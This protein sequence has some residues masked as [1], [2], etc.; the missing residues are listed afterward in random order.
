MGTDYPFFLEHDDVSEVA[1]VLRD[2]RRH[3]DEARRRARQAA[4]SFSMYESARRLEGSFTRAEGEP[5]GRSAIQ[6]LRML[7]TGHDFRFAGGLVEILESRSDIELHV[8]HWQ[9]LHEHDNGFA[10]AEFIG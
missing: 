4:R 2:G 5:S 7:L 9:T 3:L 8:A 10:R 1:R 6:R